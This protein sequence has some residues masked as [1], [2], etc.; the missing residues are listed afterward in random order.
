MKFK[1]SLVACAIYLV[2]QSAVAL[3]E[4]R[5]NA[6]FANLFSGTSSA[7]IVAEQMNKPPAQQVSF[8]DMDAGIYSAS[9]SPIPP[10][11][12]SQQPNNRLGSACTPA[13]RV[14]G[15]HP[16][17]KLRSLRRVLL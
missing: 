2:G 17:S 15:E 16:P 8:N 5:Y 3:G 10:R 7:S 13:A 14:G 4:D 1:I 11:S 12:C 6:L 9:G